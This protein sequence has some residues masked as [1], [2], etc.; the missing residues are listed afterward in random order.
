[1]PDHIARRLA[2]NGRRNQLIVD[3]YTVNHVQYG[4]TLI[5]AI[6]R[7]HAVILNELFKRQGF[8]RTILSLRVEKRMKRIA[9]E[10]AR[11]REVNLMS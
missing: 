7:N 1:M 6:N 11:L 10:L 2:D 3:E 8:E 4:K 9:N 5:F